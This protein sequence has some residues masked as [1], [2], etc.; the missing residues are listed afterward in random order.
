MKESDATY[1]CEGLAIREEY[2]ETNF[3]ED[4]IKLRDDKID[5]KVEEIQ[6]YFF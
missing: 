3:T 1:I 2:E 5:I 6:K 4:P